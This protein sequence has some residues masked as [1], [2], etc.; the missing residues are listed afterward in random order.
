MRTSPPTESG[1]SRSCRSSSETLASPTRSPKSGR[2]PAIFPQALDRQDTA[3]AS[4]RLQTITAPVLVTFGR[5]PNLNPEVARQSAGLFANAE[6]HLLE[7]AAHWPQW[8]RPE[9]VADLITQSVAATEAHA[10]Q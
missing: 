4:G 1:S 8:E 2:G 5:D 3:I 6:L 9:M 7:Q 10:R